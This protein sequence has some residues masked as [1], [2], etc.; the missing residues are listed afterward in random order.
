MYF[1]L[2]RES[3]EAMASASRGAIALGVAPGDLMAGLR[4]P[5]PHNQERIV[6]LVREHPGMLSVDT[7]ALCLGTAAANAGMG[8]FKDDGLVTEMVGRV[9]IEG[10]AGSTDAA[11]HVGTY[12]GA[13]EAINRGDMTALG[14]WMA[15]DCTFGG[16]GS[17]K[18]EIVKFVQQGKDDGWLSHNP[19]GAAAAGEFSVSVYENRFA[20]GRAVIGAGILRWNANGLCVE[21]V[22]RE[23]GAVGT[24]IGWHTAGRPGLYDPAWPERPPAQLDI[25]E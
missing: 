8:R 9:P 18:A 12:L 3:R 24:V 6:A 15:E 21:I 14:E 2:I 10:Q 16:V 25:S 13:A 11:T 7:A 1:W 22:G 5:R 17:N 19:I 23:G 4:R 20:D